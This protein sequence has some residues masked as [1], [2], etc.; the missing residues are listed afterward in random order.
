MK[1]KVL[2]ILLS[3]AIALGLWVYVITV[4]D[5]EYSR[6]YK[7]PVNTAEFQYSSVLND[8]KLTIM[9]CDEYVT[10]ELKGNRSTLAALRS[11]DLKVQA[12]VA[13]VTQ[14]GEYRLE[15]TVSLPGA[16][17]VDKQT[18]ETIYLRV[19]SVTTKE[20]EIRT[21]ILGEVP[22]GF[23]ADTEDIFEG[24]EEGKITISGPNSVLK[25]IAYAKLDG[26]IDLSGKEEDVIGTY[27]LVLYNEN[28][29][30]VDASRVTILGSKKVSVRIRVEMFKDIKLGLKITEGGGLTKADVKI[31]P[32]TIRISG[33]KAAIEALGD[34]L[35][36]GELDLSTLDMNQ[37]LEPFSI[38]LADDR[39]VNRT[40][41][42]EATVTV[43]FGELTQKTMAV[44]R[45]NTV[46]SKGLTAIPD[47][48]V[49]NVVFRGTR[50]QLDA[51]T[52]A[53]VTVDVDY[54]GVTAG[55]TAVRAAR[56]RIHNPQFRNVVAVGE[57]YE[58]SATIK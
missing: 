16:M 43:D 23:A 55:S 56:I 38:T 18:P 53:D 24:N 11:E 33:P 14:A 3:V 48:K 12:S 10:V 2:S 37:K 58:V 22:D 8:R 20:L 42:E 36:I 13:N 9:E 50:A 54:S 51:I 19:D 41:I 25:K 46:A 49:L 34:T 7:V 35:V 21:N 6:T 15:Y 31:E 4:V 27:E 45:F 52:E 57:G 47:R 32:E 39:I 44:S 1:S 5:P 28:G 29:K 17:L 30:P 40:G 26:T